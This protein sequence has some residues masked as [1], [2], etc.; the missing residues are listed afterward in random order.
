MAVQVFTH[1]QTHKVIGTLTNGMKVVETILT[2]TDDSTATAT[3][4]L[5]SPL[6]RVTKFIAGSQTFTTGGIMAWAAHAA[7][8]LNVITATP[9]SSAINDV[10]TII[11]FGY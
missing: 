4:I 5:I 6:K 11:S 9:A 7:P 2:V 1:T 3:D 10:F 8:E